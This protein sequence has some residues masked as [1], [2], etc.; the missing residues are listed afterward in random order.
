MDKRVRERRRLV[1]RDR[2]RRR[3]WLIFLIVLV[4]VALAAFLWLRSS[5]VFAVEGVTASAT[6][7]V[8]KQQIAE[9]VAPARGVSLLKLSTDPIE[10]ALA[11]LPYVRSVHVYRDFP[12]G[13]DVQIEE[14]KPV[15]KVQAGDGK[16]WLI[17]DDGRL[18]EKATQAAG[19]G[20]PLV[21]GA[22]QFSAEAG[23][24][25]PKELL[26][27]LPVVQELG[28]AE[29][30]SKLPAIEY[31]SVTTGGAVV[32]HLQGGTELRLGEPVDLKQKMMDAATIIENYLR[33]GKSLEY[34]DASAG[35][36]LTAKAK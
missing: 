19:G 6:Q 18:L 9:A 1:S 34:V 35:D 26:A 21:T 8:T 5:S 22:T 15:A 4:F 24:M 25:V 12:N 36:R 30:S 32:L 29:V 10:K 17:A 16:A 31:I 33:D 11:S 7:H 27:A 20:L 14:Y 23:G 3:A 28:L 13:L 2:G